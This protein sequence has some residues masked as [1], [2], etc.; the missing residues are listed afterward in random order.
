MF[1]DAP[2]YLLRPV[3]SGLF[4]ILVFVGFQRLFHARVFCLLSFDY[5]CLIVYLQLE[6]KSTL[7][8]ASAPTSAALHWISS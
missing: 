2:T 3:P 6:Q 1:S 4:V 5:L 7:G 8:T